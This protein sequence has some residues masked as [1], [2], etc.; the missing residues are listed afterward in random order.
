MAGTP[1]APYP[2]EWR[3]GMLRMRL[4]GDPE[5]GAIMASFIRFGGYLRARGLPATTGRMIELL[6]SIP[7]LDLHAPDELYWASRCLLTERVS[8]LAVFDR[9][10]FEFFQPQTGG[11]SE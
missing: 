7:W 10:F 4:M 6:R 2:S 9:A 1:D 11:D 5:P 8:D 3:P